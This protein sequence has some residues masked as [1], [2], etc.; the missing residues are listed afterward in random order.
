[1]T[2]TNTSITEYAVDGKWTEWREWES[3]S[4]SCGGGSQ[5]SRRS[6]TNP[7]PAFGGADCEG[8]SLRSRSC[9]E[10]GC[11]GKYPKHI[12]GDNFCHL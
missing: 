8:A 2:F 1:M 5:M 10:N 7:A 12:C 11:P 9:N 4:V 6:C 3:C